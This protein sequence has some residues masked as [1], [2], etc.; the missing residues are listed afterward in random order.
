MVIEK[1][2]SASARRTMESFEAVEEKRDERRCNLEIPR[3][4]RSLIKVNAQEDS[5]SMMAYLE[6]VVPSDGVRDCERCNLCWN[7]RCNICQFRR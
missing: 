6:R 5:R 1:E 4:L 3:W 7:E 2:A